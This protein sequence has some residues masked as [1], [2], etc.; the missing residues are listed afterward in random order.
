MVPVEFHESVAEMPSIYVRVHICC[1]TSVCYAFKNNWKHRK[2]MSSTWSSN[3][4]YPQ[5]NLA[6]KGI[7]QI[8]LYYYLFRVFAL[9]DAQILQY[10]YRLHIFAIEDALPALHTVVPILLTHFCSRGCLDILQ[11]QYCLHFFAIE[12][13]LILY[14]VRTTVAWK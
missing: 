8:L 4:S 1:N 6:H 5:L 14:T 2:K 7:L 3:C 12:D 9:E 11:Y 13:A 10:Q